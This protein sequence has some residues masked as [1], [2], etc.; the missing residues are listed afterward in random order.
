[1][2]DREDDAPHLRKLK[3]AVNDDILRNLELRLTRQACNLYEAE[4]YC[5]YANIQVDDIEKALL[6]CS[7]TEHTQAYWSFRE[8]VH[9]FNTIVARFKSVR[10]FSLTNLDSRAIPQEKPV[11]VVQP[12]QND[13]DESSSDDSD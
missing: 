7:G 2:A 10:A 6:H 3:N 1:M 5:L 8:A 4:R 11:A 9:N 12:S 13:S